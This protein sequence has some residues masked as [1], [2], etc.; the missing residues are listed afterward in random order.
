VV[1]CP[2][3]SKVVDK[4]NRETRLLVARL[5]SRARI[6]TDDGARRKASSVTK[7]GRQAADIEFV[8]EENYGKAKTDY[9]A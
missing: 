3:S 1:R 4:L 6:N 8:S 5:G 9:E 7:D 2:C